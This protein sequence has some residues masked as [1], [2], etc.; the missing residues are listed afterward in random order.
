MLLLAAV[1]I[2]RW[3]IILDKALR[4]VSLRRETRRLE[5]LATEKAV[6]DASVQTIDLADGLFR[7]RGPFG[8]ARA[9]NLALATGRE[10]TMPDWARS[11]PWRTVLPRLAP[12]ARAAAGRRASGGDR[13]GR[14]RSHGIAEPQLS[15]MAWRSAVIANDLAGRAYYALPESARLVEWGTRPPRGAQGVA[16]SGLMRT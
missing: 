8:A 14:P 3:A 12:P 10:P 7:L 1:S 2:V 16:A 9:R 15:L 11:F 13:G 4:V 6:T 5:V